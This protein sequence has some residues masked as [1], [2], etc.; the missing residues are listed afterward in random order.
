MVVALI[1]QRAE[2]EPK[3]RAAGLLPVVVERMVKV[4]PLTTCTPPTV[5]VHVLVW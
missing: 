2:S 5:A 3:V 1:Y 4:A